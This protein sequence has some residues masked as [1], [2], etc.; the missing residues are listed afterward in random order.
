LIAAHRQ[1][2]TRAP[3]T[4]H[5]ERVLKPLTPLTLSAEHAGRPV[6]RREPAADRLVDEPDHLVECGSD[7][8]RD[9]GVGLTAAA[10][11]AHGFLSTALRPAER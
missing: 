5:R 6:S 3:K 7:T 11:P 4:A 8:R 2:N 10:F 9:S 1:S